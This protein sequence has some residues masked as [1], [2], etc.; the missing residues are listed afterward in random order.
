MK[1]VLSNMSDV[2]DFVSI[3]SPGYLQAVH[4]EL[5]ALA[6]SS[7]MMSAAA[8]NNLSVHATPDTLPADIAKPIDPMAAATYGHDLHPEGYRPTE[9]VGQVPVYGDWSKTEDLPTSAS[10]DKAVVET[11]AALR[12]DQVVTDF[13]AI[14]VACMKQVDAAFAAERARQTP[15]DDT[16]EVGTAEP[17]ELDSTGRRWDEEI[18]SAAKTKTKAGAWTRS[19]RRDLTDER[20]NE[21]A[22]ELIA[23]A[24][25]NWAPDKEFEEPVATETHALPGLTQADF[26]GIDVE[27]E[28]EPKEAKPAVDLAALIEASADT[29]LELSGSMGDLMAASRT[30]IEAHGVQAMNELRAAVAPDPNNPAVGL[31][32]GSLT[33]AQR[34]LVQ[35]CIQNYPS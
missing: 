32:V 26:D 25:A 9:A 6:E 5:R 16:T 21:R 29:S 17:E 30:F 2:E 10:A 7:G 18:D 20:Y 15:G 34:A 3:L 1:I 14:G 4:P 35:A 24:Q 8:I 11:S 19:R 28:T 23:E 33:P 12:G 22:A 27:A 31:S 13:G